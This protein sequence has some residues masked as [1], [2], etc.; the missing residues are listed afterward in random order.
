MEYVKIW[1]DSVLVSGSLNLVRSIWMFGIEFRII[2]YCSVK[3]RIDP[4]YFLQVELFVDQFLVCS[5]GV[6]LEFCGYIK[7]DV[8]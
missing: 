1:I 2:H 7:I 5:F 8:L 3:F 6:S 4:W